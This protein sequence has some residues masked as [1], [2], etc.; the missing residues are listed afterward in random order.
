MFFN[1]ALAEE[2]S[3]GRTRLQYYR[4]GREVVCSLENLLAA[5]GRRLGDCDRVLEMACGYGRVTRHLVRELA[6]HRITAA[7][8]LAPAVGF[9][10]G[11]F[12]VDARRSCTEPEAFDV[13][14]GFD[15]VFVSSLFSHL[16][17]PR[18]EAWLTRLYDTLAPEGLLVF[19]THGPAVRPEVPKDA[20][21]FTF[22]P[23]SESRELEGE[24][25]GSTFVSRAVVE[26]IAGRCGVAH[27]GFLERELWMVQDVVVASP[28]PVPGPSSW[29]NTSFVQGVVD[30]VILRDGQF[31]VDGWAA[32]G[33]RDAPLAAVRLLLD[34][35]LVAE[36]PVGGRRGDVAAQL[37]RTDWAASGWELHGTLPELPAGRHLVAAQGVTADGTEG[38]F[39]IVELEL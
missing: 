28:A 27:L 17:R 39:E 3:P 22:V 18:F 23:S 24:E 37:G 12:G 32:D 26:E 14:R 7:E 10:G 15:L 2:A 1:A 13:G 25:Y 34:G 19:S 31:H 38:V 8:I 33:R 5:A 16:P 29:Q 6:P 36:V 4:D 21:G 30:R 20:S 35:R 11:T 9:V